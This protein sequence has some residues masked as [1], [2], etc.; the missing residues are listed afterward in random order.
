MPIPSAVGVWTHDS[1]YMVEIPHRRSQVNAEDRPLRHSPLCFAILYVGVP[2]G[3][4]GS[5]D[6]E[7]W[8]QSCNCEAPEESK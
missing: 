8:G 7:A 4:D 6:Y 2:I 5:L 1:V 3:E